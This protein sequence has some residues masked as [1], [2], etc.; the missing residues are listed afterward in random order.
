MIVVRFKMQCRPDKTAALREAL[1]AVITPARTT[2]GVS[3]S[4]SRR[5]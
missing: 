5:I 4:T 3:A 2:E 1:A